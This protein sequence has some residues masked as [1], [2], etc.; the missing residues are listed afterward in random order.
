MCKPLKIIV[1]HSNVL[2]QPYFWLG[3][4][5]ENRAHD[6]FLHLKVHL[7][8]SQKFPTIPHNESFY[9]QLWQTKRIICLTHFFVFVFGLLNHS[10]S[11]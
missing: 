4:K 9:L 6:D 1:L 2:T 10:K 5:N 3:M 11:K 8:V 7:Q